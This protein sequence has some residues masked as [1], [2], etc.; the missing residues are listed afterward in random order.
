MLILLDLFLISRNRESVVVST[1]TDVDWI[2]LFVRIR[3]AFFLLPFSFC[4][5]VEDD[6]AL[7]EA[8]RNVKRNVVSAKVSRVAVERDGKTNRIC[9]FYI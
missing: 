8:D 7:V 3:L 1:D 4:E 9:I 2:A 5:G 6:F